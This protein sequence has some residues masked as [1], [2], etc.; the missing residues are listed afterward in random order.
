MNNR[1][2]EGCLG[3]EGMFLTI[4][5]CLGIL[6][7]GLTFITFQIWETR[8]HGTLLTTLNYFSVNLVIALEV[9]EVVTPNWRD[10]RDI[11]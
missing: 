7:K 8:D 6:G 5:N 2:I 3:S 9:A 1:E 11:L 10:Y 4:V